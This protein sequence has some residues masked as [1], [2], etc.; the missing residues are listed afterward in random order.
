MA[1]LNHIQNLILQGEHQT[2]DFKHCITDSKKIARSLAAFAN[3]DGGTLLIGVKDNGNIVGVNSDEEYYMVEAAAQ[4]YCRPTLPFGVTKW[5]IN[6]KTVLEVKVKPSKRRPHKAPNKLG[7]Y[8]AYVR[9]ADENIIATP[10]QVKIWN[11]E[12]SKKTVQMNISTVENNL[13][14]YLNQHQSITVQ[15]FSKI[16]FMPTADAEK[17][18]VSLVVLGLLKYK[19]QQTDEIFSLVEE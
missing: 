11:L 15:Q 8:R 12:R 18:L 19:A 9:A 17:T 1:V 4:M 3:T 13:F 6:G 16:G 7:E 10:I 14:Q 5:S 2:L